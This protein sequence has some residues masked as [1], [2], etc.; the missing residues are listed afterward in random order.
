MSKRTKLTPASGRHSWIKS[1]LHK[2]HQEA[3]KKLRQQKSEYT[4]IRVPIPKE[5]YPPF[6]SNV[7]KLRAGDP[8]VVDE[9]VPRQVAGEEWLSQLL[10]SEAKCSWCHRWDK[11]AGKSGGW[12]SRKL[13]RTDMMRETIDLRP[14]HSRALEY[15][16]ESCP[17]AMVIDAMDKI[18]RKKIA[19]FEEIY[20]RKVLFVA[21]H[22]DSGQMHHDLWHSGINEV[23]PENEGLKEISHGKKARHRGVE[24]NPRVLTPFRS[25][26]VSVGAASW[27]RHFDAFRE[28]GLQEEEI[29]AFAGDTM[30]ALQGSI[31]TAEMQNGEYPR[32]LRLQSELDAFVGELFRE[33]DPKLV[34]R[35]LKEYVNDRRTGYVQGGVGL[36]LSQEARLASGLTELLERAEGAERREAEQKTLR[37]AA[38]T[39]L[40]K[41]RQSLGI[42]IRSLG[43]GLL[44]LVKGN[45]AASEEFQKLKGVT[46]GILIPPSP[47]ESLVALQKAMARLDQSTTGEEGP[48]MG[49]P[50]VKKR[51]GPSMG[52][53]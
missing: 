43:A 52:G 26:G 35:A 40:S 20:G 36:T 10:A 28:A 14:D 48:F 49:G 27:A 7:S 13:P 3:Q 1:S 29:K 50:G 11:S 53:P 32:D 5:V 25:Y 12:K 23:D 47:R 17:R 19:L 9:G 33:I 30:D 46:E 22:D 24:V 42:F 34:D 6:R 41:I 31:E 8:Y 44:K 38:E 51:K 4:V 21:E 45:P 39:Q 15:L 2:I 16:L 18:R 37:E